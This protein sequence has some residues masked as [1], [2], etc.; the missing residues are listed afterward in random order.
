MKK[1]SPVISSR[2]TYRKLFIFLITLSNSLLITACGGSSTSVSMP[3]P[4]TTTP[5]LTE[6]PITPP[7]VTP[8]TAPQQ[9]ATNPLYNLNFIESYKLDVPEPSGLSWALNHKDFY[10][11]D[12]RTNTVFEIDKQGNTL[13][14]NYHYAGKDLEGISIDPASQTVWLAEESKS[15]LKQLDADGNEINSYKLEIVRDSKKHS[16][17]GISYDPVENNFYILNEK[18]PGLLIRWQPE[19]GMTDQTLLNFAGDYSGIFFDQTDSSLWII[20]DQSQK[21]FHCDTDGVV[22]QSFELGFKKAEGIVVD[23]ENERIYAVS[24]TKHRLYVYSLTPQ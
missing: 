1:I 12:D 20:S 18:D 22:I 15:R 24:D 4:P 7:P 21:L 16:L 3:Q 23:R 19:L 11:V 8:P 10:V 9:P 2:R 6:S 17:E 13:R 5:P 14:Y